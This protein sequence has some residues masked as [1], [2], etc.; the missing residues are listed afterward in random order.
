M[1][2]KI[3][4]FI[5]C[6][7][8]A[9][10]RTQGDDLGDMGA[11][12]HDIDI[13]IGYALSTAIG[14]GSNPSDLRS[15]QVTVNGKEVCSGRKNGTPLDFD[16]F[17]G[18]D[19]YENFE[20]NGVKCGFRCKFQG[21]EDCSFTFGGY[22]IKFNANECERFNYQD[23]VLD[24]GENETL[25]SFILGSLIGIDGPKCSMNRNGVACHKTSV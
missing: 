2:F 7:L 24:S 21:L 5:L 9:C 12:N 3:L 8:L 16:Y 19:L 14:I 20:T 25:F 18:G 22:D 4:L 1:Y 17:N 13:K 23:C 15:M 6:F 11:V 10:V